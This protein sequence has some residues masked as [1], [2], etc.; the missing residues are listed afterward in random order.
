MK[1]VI[2]GT[3][4]H[5]DHGK[6]CLI[7]A[8]TGTNT[9]RLKEEQKRGITIELGFANLPNDTD[10]KIGIIDVPG[11]EKFVKNMLA[12]IGGIDLVLMVI[13][14]DEG[15]MPQ[16][17]EHFEILK[18]LHIKQG[19]IVLT[20]ADLV[21]Q[22]WAELVRAD[23]ESMVEG[24][25]LEG[26]EMVEVSAFTGQNI[27][28]LKELIVAMVQNAGERKT[29]EALFRLPIDRVFT[30][31]GFGTVVTG[32]L[33]EGSCKVSDDVC[34]YPSEQIVKIRGIQVHGEKA[35]EADAG[36]RTAINLANI[37]K[38]AVERGNVLAAMGSMQKTK[39]IDTKISLFS[40]V[41]RGLKNGD[42][43]HFNYGSAQ[44]I[45]KAVLLDKDS[46][47]PGDTG[48]VQLRFD[49]EIAIKRNDRFI[50]R[51]FSPVVTFGG[52]I[53]L[54]AAAIKHKHCDSETLRDLQIKDTGNELEVLA[55]F[56]KEGSHRFPKAALLAV[57][58]GWTLDE[59]NGYL[60]ELIAKGIA[61][62][63]G[64]EGYLHGEYVDKIQ[65]FTKTL[66]TAFHKANPIIPGMG[67]EEFRNKLTEEFHL[68]EPR[69]IETLLTILI[70]E[71]VIG[72]DQNYVALKNFAAAYTKELGGVREE[73]V[74]AYKEAGFEVP[75]CEDILG[76]TRDP[77]MSKLILEDLVKNEILVKISYPYFMEKEC[78]NQA[79]EKLKQY[80]KDHNEI[81]L[82]EYRDLLGT[83]RKF[84]V[85][86]LE[87]FDQQ[88]LTKKIG[89]A[90]TLR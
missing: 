50:I 41:N 77:K 46:L 89:D 60:D 47:G 38:E 25:F 84:A 88:K 80:L 34:L 24:T 33:M 90:R 49:E 20:K 83:S 22:E 27:N 59:T 37:K 56:L 52:G 65:E 31:E 28:Y 17:M 72:L 85:L 81:T 21:D 36:Q 70:Q 6:T 69:Y 40:S 42:R 87:S 29:E 13:A 44:T 23:V 58:L 45:A 51:F 3:A 19:I 74:K 7:K 82:G 8:L 9:D 57:E 54:D 53:I 71:K 12:G 55:I 16:T 73:I 86:L 79:V 4:G 48:F 67:K 32:T 15:V 61:K 43:V 66:L 14:L 39:M 76:K 78:F 5:V 62:K 2:V 68:T 26:A 10:T 18:M 64:E 11:H 75:P 35:V 63:A 30:M 1:N